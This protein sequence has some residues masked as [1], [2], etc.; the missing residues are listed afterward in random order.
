VYCGQTVGWIKMP[1]GTE[2]GL[3]PGDIVLDGDS[4]PKQKGSTTD[5]AF[6]PVSIVTKRSPISAT[7]ELLFVKECV[8]VT[9]Q[10]TSRKES[11]STSHRPR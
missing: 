6:R 11:H 5:P 4:A 3:G 8:S 10:A 2:V 1:L 9:R 7:A